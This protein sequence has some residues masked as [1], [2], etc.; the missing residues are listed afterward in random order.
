MTYF[1]PL[2]Q[3]F[4]RHPF[5]R[6]SLIF[7]LWCF[8]IGLALPA[9]AQIHPLVGCAMTGTSPVNQT[10]TYT[11]TINAGCSPQVA[12]AW[13]ATHANILS[14]TQTTVTVNFDDF[15]SYTC[16]ITAYA[17]VSGTQPIISKTVTINVPSTLNGGSIT[18]TT[19]P[20]INYNTAPLIIN[21]NS[22]AGGSCTDGYAYTWQSSPDSANWTSITDGTGYGQNYQS[23]PLT[24]KTYFRRS[25][26]CGSQNVLTLNTAVVNVYPQIVP[27]TITPASQATINY[28]ATP[29]GLSISN[30]SGGNGTYSYQWQDSTNG[31]TWQSVGSPGNSY[32]P[33]PLTA[34]TWFRVAVNS[35]GAIVN[36]APVT[37]NVYPQLLVGVISPTLQTINYNSPAATLSIFPASGGNG[38]YSYQWWTDS[39]GS[40]QPISGAIGTSHSPGS[41]LATAHYKVVVTSNGVQATSN[42]A[43]VTVYPQLISGTISPAPQQIAYNTAPATLSLAGTT[44]GNGTYSYQWYSDA[45][46]SFQPVGTLS[47]YTPGPLTTTTHFY[48]IVSSNGVSATSPTVTV[49]VGPPPPPD[50]NYIRTRTVKKPGVPDKTTADGLSDVND[51]EQS[52]T[53]FDGLGRSVQTVSRQAS[54][55]GY[56][57]VVPQ[58]YDSFGREAL[59]YLPYVSPASDGMNRSNPLAEQSTFNSAQFPGEQFYYGQTVFEASPLNRPVADYSAGN[60]WVGSN[61]G[62]TTGYLTNATTDSVQIWNISLVTGSLPVNGGAYA[63]GQL[64]KTTTTDEQQHTVEEYKDK[65]GHVIL[66][67]VQSW[68][69]PAAG[70]SGWLCTYYVYDDLNNLRFVLPP[71]AVELTSNTGWVVSQGI[72]DELCFRYEYDSRNRM[73]IKKIPGAGEM[74]MVYDVRDRLV[75]SQDA[76]QR[77]KNEW[78][79]MQYDGLNRMLITGL[80]M[81]TSTANALQQAVTSQTLAGGS[82]LSLVPTLDLSTPNESGVFQASQLITMDSG[83]STAIDSAFTADITNF[84]NTDPGYGADGLAV[85]VSAVPSGATIQPLI[86]NYYDNYNWIASANPG[87]GTTLDSTHTRDGNYFITTYNT[88]PTY[89][90]PVTADAGTRGQL[91]G[92]MHLVLDENRPL[93]AVNFYDDRARLIQSQSMNYTGGIDTLTS[94]YDFSGKVLRSLFTHYKAGHTAQYHTVLTKM[95]YD[96]NFRLR[97]IWKNIDSATTDQL[98]DSLQYNELGQLRAKYLGNNLDSLEYDYNIRGW[99]NGINKK[100]VGGKTNNYFGMEL[101]YDKTGS[102]DGT[103][104]Y[105]NPAYNGNIAGTI[106]K[107]AGDG[108]NRKYDFSYDNISRLTGAAYLDNKSGAWTKTSNS[109]DFTVSNLTYDAN[110]NIMSMSQN[111]FKIGSPAA[112]IDRLTYAYQPNSNKLN[113]VKDSANDPISTLGDFHYNASTKDSSDYNYDGNGNLTLDNNKAI[114]T[115]IY[116]Y[117]NLPQQVHIN[118]KGTILYTYDASGTKLKKVTMDSLSHHSTTTLYQGGF[119]Y[120]QTDTISNPGGGVDTLQFAGHE[121]GRARWA[122]HK[123]A[124]G[125]SGYGWEYDFF[126]KDHLGNTRVLLTQEKDTANYIATMEAAYRANEMALFYNIDSTSYPT[127]SVPGGYPV[128]GTTKPNDSVARVNGSGHKMGPALLLKV[129]SGD[130]LGIGVKSFYRSNGSPGSN[131][132]SLPDVLNSLAQGLVSVAGPGHGTF[133]GLNTSGSPVYTALNS[134]L[135]AND[136]SKSGKPKAY[137]NWMLLDNQFNYVGGGGQSGALQVGGPDVLNTLAQGIGIHHSGYLYIWVSNETQNWDVF[138]DNLSVSHYSGPMLEENHYYPFG[139]SMSGISDHSLKSNYVENKYRFNKGSELQNKEF[140]DGSGLELY[141]TPLRSLDPQL[142]R[143]W[144]IDSKPTEAESPYSAMG[145]NPILHNDPLGDSLPSGRHVWDAGATEEMQ[146]MVRLNPDATFEPSFAERLYLIGEAIGLFSFPEAQIAKGAKVTKETVDLGQRANEIHSTLSPITQT[147]TTTAVASATTAEGKDVILVAS[148]EKNLRP[149]QR[150]ALKDGEIAVS[151]PGHAE[152][153][154]INHAEKNG[155]T[156]KEVAASRPICSSCAAAINNAGAQPASVLKA[157]KESNAALPIPL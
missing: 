88:T 4:Q 145:N 142:G 108:V 149:A 18:T 150:A 136:T 1:A 20:T 65:D 14:F 83:F 129:M 92:T 112:P 81:Y 126:E 148:S 120:Q 119:V 109:M 121:E 78:L 72:A 105:L 96:A 51:V 21:A 146:Q 116:N 3:Y 97:H 44:G 80:M 59:H 68:D 10:G 38:T 82:S 63:A 77:G 45:S 2:Q 60:S 98:I 118:G 113:Q 5:L 69:I 125:S 134:F 89:A 127:A 47:T 40:Y 6:R 107:S 153:T 39:S 90:V 110:G 114:D 156:V 86:I 144:Q 87:L 24:A 52:T 13:S 23:G 104:G 100:Y 122:F 34:T 11:Y 106:W 132:S 62:V 137:L 15:T 73:I 26:Y 67:K 31:I 42:E 123:Y 54:P 94:Q 138:F 22:S 91:T 35:N 103:T 128:D 155:M 76:N 57:L 131:N 8:V 36:S 29:L 37:I 71:R 85:N 133:A 102:I 135:P 43:S 46:G 53:Y 130:S 41:L 124:T 66:K 111:G 143:W 84:N 93:F 58:V 117:L 50:L 30:A 99:V 151:G 9:R 147:K 49:T 115:I 17:D 64:Y 70:H 7:G 61:R 101:G 28:G 95:D 79:S 75:F 19:Q 152:Q 16:V 12:L 141:E 74:D 27:G 154:I 25:T 48:V 33:G 55:L 139:L 157:I 32:S 56:D 140:A